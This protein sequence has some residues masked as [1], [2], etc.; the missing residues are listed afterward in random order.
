MKKIPSLTQLA[1]SV[2]E[3]FSTS[4]PNHHHHDS[5]NPHE[6]LRKTAN[7][8]D[9]DDDDYDD[10]STS[11]SS[12]SSVIYSLEQHDSTEHDVF[13]TPTIHHHSHHHQQN[14]PRLTIDVQSASQ[15]KNHSPSPTSPPPPP[16]LTSSSS[17][18]D[19]TR[20]HHGSSFFHHSL[21]SANLLQK[22][23]SH[24]HHPPHTSTTSTSA[25]TT[26]TNSEDALTLVI[27]LQ[28]LLLEE[29]LLLTQEKQSVL[30]S[31]QSINTLRSTEIPHLL[32]NLRQYHTRIKQLNQLL[33]IDILM[34]NNEWNEALLSELDNSSS[35][36]SGDYDRHHQ[37]H[38]FFDH[39][40]QSSSSHNSNAHATSNTNNT[41]TT[42]SSFSNFVSNASSNLHSAEHAIQKL[43]NVFSIMRSSSGGSH[44][45][46]HA[47]AQSSQQQQ[48]QLPHYNTSNNYSPTNR[49]Q[50]SVSSFSLASISSSAN[51]CDN[52]NNSNANSYNSSLLFDD[53]E[54]MLKKTRIYRLEEKDHPLGASK[55]NFESLIDFLRCQPTI[56][57]DCCKNLIVQSQEPSFATAA[58][59]QHQQ[60]QQ[61]QQQ[62]KM[63]N[64]KKN[65]DRLAEMILFTLY[66]NSLND[67]FEG[68][69]LLR[70]IK[71][72]IHIVFNSSSS[73]LSS[74]SSS[75]TPHNH[76]FTKVTDIMRNDFI[77]QLLLLFMK[78]QGS[79]FICALINESLYTLL[80]NDDL[81]IRI[82]GHAPPP[83]RESLA[84]SPSPLSRSI[85][86]SSYLSSS[87]H[88]SSPYDDLASAAQTPVGVHNRSLSS[89]YVIGNG[90]AGGRNL[91]MGE[92][93]L[94]HPFGMESEEERQKRQQASM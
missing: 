35:G 33:N 32:F 67:H 1:N 12:S 84:S 20:N 3:V 9:D 75:S 19:N 16:T 30:N 63:M 29:Q 27:S 73:S 4:H 68:R 46:Q 47:H 57:I 94:I 51:K 50:R 26:T 85:S 34:M 53:M 22:L 48:Q 25:T 77:R 24:H 49:V 11:S 88:Y 89:N 93:D 83:S 66:G 39:D 80:Q 2:V 86:S 21:S 38:E 41:A 8:G 52:G 15:A 62:Q 18:N 60:Q 90:R 91:S 56:F 14:A 59:Q 71:Q 44:S 64:R 13:I 6:L 40:N 69:N 82:E 17:S 23:S 58:N 61:Q 28:Q 55:L 42:T 31:V 7:G 37:E 5:V 54:A 36:S 10:E 43:A 81:D 70:L 65:S 72:A 45:Q 92:H 74:L 87:L 79:E 76:H 78:Q